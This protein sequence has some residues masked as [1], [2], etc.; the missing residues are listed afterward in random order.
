MVDWDVCVSDM[1]NT[2]SAVMVCAVG[3]FVID[4]RCWILSE[5]ISLLWNKIG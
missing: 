4:F 5:G 2:I 3:F 1:Q